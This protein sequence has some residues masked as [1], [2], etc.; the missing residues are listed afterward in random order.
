MMAN[1][2]PS[3]S[4]LEV[5]MVAPCAATGPQRMRGSA[6]RGRRRSSPRLGARLNANIRGRP[7][8]GPGRVSSICYCGRARAAAARRTCSYSRCVI[9][10]MMPGRSG[11]RTCARARATGP[12]VSC[13]G[14]A[15][16][17]DAAPSYRAACVA[18]QAPR[19]AAR[20]PGVRRV[21]GNGERGRRRTTSS[22]CALD[23]SRRGAGPTTVRVTS[24]IV[25]WSTPTKTFEAGTSDEPR[26]AERMQVQISEVEATHGMRAHIGIKAKLRKVDGIHTC[27]LI[28][29]VGAA[30]A[31]GT[32]GRT[33]EDLAA[34]ARHE[35]R[36]RRVARRDVWAVPRLAAPSTA[37][38]DPP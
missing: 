15:S 37:R 18:A 38:S 20:A 30:P 33:G 6:Q 23:G 1:S 17:S 34:V 14:T 5:V 12:R 21:P 13:S 11:P 24:S 22:T 4:I 36:R 29:G 26:I 25:S 7:E 31:G 3:E 27:Q 32:A 2:S 8:T 28:I 19:R 16:G 10:E 35:R 9:C